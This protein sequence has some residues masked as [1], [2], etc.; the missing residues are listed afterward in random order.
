MDPKAEG[1]E[2]V[3]RG[4]RLDKECSM[5]HFDIGWHFERSKW[6]SAHRHVTVFP[7]LGPTPTSVRQ[8]GHHTHPEHDAHEH[9]FQR[10]FFLAFGPMPGLHSPQT[11]LSRAH[12]WFGG[13]L[14]LIILSGQLG[15][16]QS[17]R[18]GRGNARP[19]T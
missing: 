3:F 11:S 17:P 18:V 6:N 12:S 4:G 5:T 14:E 15:T 10:P 13:P 8:G 16:R 9:F 7:S 2:G 19:S 1:G